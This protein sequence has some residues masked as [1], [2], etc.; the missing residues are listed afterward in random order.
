M[1]KTRSE[2]RSPSAA[3]AP[4]DPTIILLALDQLAPSPLNPRK[5]FEPYALAELAASIE[6]DGLLQN[7]VVRP[8]PPKDG[9]PAYEI[10]AG[11]RR[12]RALNLLWERGVWDGD[13]PI[14]PCRV[15]DADDVGARAIA[16]LENLQRQDISPI[17]EG[18]AFRALRDLDAE[19][20]S[21]AAI[22]E[23]IRRTQRY[24]Q[25]RLA[26]VTKLD[27]DLQ[28]ALADGRLNVEQARFLTS[29]PADVQKE[30]LEQIG[31]SWLST[32]NQLRDY[33]LRGMIP[34]SRAAFPLEQYTGERVEIDGADEVWLADR[35][36][37]MTLQKAAAKQ[38]VAELRKEWHW[39][40]LVEGWLSSW[41][42]EAGRSKDRKKAGA[43][44]VF[45]HDG[46]IEV[47][48]GLVKKEAAA[49]PEAQVNDGLERRQRERDAQEKLEADLAE[50]LKRQ[51]IEE[52]I[53]VLLLA[54]E[55]WDVV[56]LLQL[57]DDRAFEPLAI[58][59]ALAALPT[60]TLIDVAAAAA[61]K[62]AAPTGWPPAQQAAAAV[63]ERYEVELP[64]HLRPPTAAEKAA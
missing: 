63:A 26:L 38:R 45:S 32:P 19:R 9:R 30:V 23:R 33:V 25:Q 46:S 12:Y 55:H 60:P 11:E 28:A 20:W 41:E 14:I 62:G 34:A 58:W 37:F 49:R 43:V 8:R 52:L 4:A 36:Q 64:E 54:L 44:V 24:V 27:P 1:T 40:K 53:R 29:A 42:Y 47:K 7:L 2:R 5:T 3:A 51:P 13:A 10:V 56:Q 61:A 6:A 35:Q 39:A 48:T 18:E 59:N 17:E 31:K 57:P 15:I 21:T 50:A 16:L 22:A